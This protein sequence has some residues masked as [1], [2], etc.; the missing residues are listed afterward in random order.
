M[1]WWWL[2]HLEG[3]GT[4]QVAG[5]LKKTIVLLSMVQEGGGKVSASGHY[6]VVIK[7]CMAKIE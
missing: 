4:N 3:R 6:E 1:Y 2:T 5:S 7:I